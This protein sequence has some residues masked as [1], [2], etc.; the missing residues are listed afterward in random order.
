MK[1]IKDTK[2]CHEREIQKYI[3]EDDCYKM[4]TT[5][6]MA[7]KVLEESTNTEF[8]KEYEIQKY[9]S[10][11]ECY[12]MMATAHKDT[13]ICTLINIDYLKQECLDEVNSKN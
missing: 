1:K 4:I 3:Q 5:L 7:Q 9:L 10:Q 6:Q 11:E 13:K 12:K 2:L 8:C